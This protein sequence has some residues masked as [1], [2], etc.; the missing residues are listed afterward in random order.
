MPAVQ[1][2]TYAQFINEARSYVAEMQ[3]SKTERDRARLWL[4]LLLIET[5]S[6]AILWRHRYDSWDKLL[7]AEKLA[8]VGI[9]SRF[10]QGHRLLG[11][12]LVR[13]LG[14]AV[15]IA[16]VNVTPKVRPQV[17]EDVKRWLRKNPRATTEETIYQVRKIVRQLDATKMTQ[18]RLVAYVRLLQTKLRE[19]GIRVPSPPNLA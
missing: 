7:R 6:Q 1:V 11:D 18:T 2:D 8:S 5:E 17:I 9:Y 15:T 19:N 14:V 12:L 3:K 10:L 4:M 13:R 16:I